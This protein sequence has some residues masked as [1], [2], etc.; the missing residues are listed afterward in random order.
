MA[1]SFTKGWPASFILAA[2]WYRALDHRGE[3]GGYGVDYISIV[4]AVVVGIGGRG[5][6]LRVVRLLL[7][8]LQKWP[9]STWWPVGAVKL[10]VPR[11]RSVSR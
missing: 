4:V 6:V 10:H 5:V 8:L 3:G 7:C 2:D 11:F 9:P 1:A